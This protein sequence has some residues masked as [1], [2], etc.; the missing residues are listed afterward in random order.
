MDVIESAK[1]YADSE[2]GGSYESKDSFEA[3]AKWMFD[4]ALGWLAKNLPYIIDEKTFTVR[5]EILRDFE[6]AMKK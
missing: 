6:K 2:W 5:R 1:E 3:G 4:K